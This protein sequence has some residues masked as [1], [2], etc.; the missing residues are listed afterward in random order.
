[1]ASYDDDIDFEAVELTLSDDEVGA[2][3]KAIEFMD[4]NNHINSVSVNAFNIKFYN[5]DDELTDKTEY[6]FD[7]A[8]V[9]VYRSGACYL[10]MINKWDS[11]NQVETKSFSI[12]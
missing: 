6:R 8:Y 4:S 2:I 9:N 10:K 1:M 11:N 12:N 7:I 5:E 3:E